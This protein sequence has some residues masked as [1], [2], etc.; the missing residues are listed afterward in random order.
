MQREQGD[1][2]S[3]SF[4]LILNAIFNANRTVDILASIQRL[5]QQHIVATSNAKTKTKKTFKLMPENNETLRPNTN[6]TYEV[7]IFRC[8]LDQN[9]N[10]KNVNIFCFT[11]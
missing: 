8:I 9:K 1:N 10:I 5:Q 7:R 3:I 2:A 11:L 6:Q 4:Q